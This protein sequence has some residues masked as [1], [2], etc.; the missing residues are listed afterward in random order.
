M[1]RGVLGLLKSIG[2]SKHKVFHCFE[3]FLEGLKAVS[4][5][6]G[7]LQGGFHNQLSFSTDRLKL[8]FRQMLN[9]MCNL[10][11]VLIME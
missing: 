2:P 9:K 8:I 11:Y 5:I 6:L 7:N 4:N 1:E 3:L 10:E